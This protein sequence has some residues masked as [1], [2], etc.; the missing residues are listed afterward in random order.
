G[1]QPAGL[2]QRQDRVL[3]GRRRT[4]AGDRP[5]LL[6][7]LRHARLERRRE[8][9]VTQL[10]E[11]GVT[12]RQ[13]AVDQKRVVGPGLGGG[14]GVHGRGLGIL[15]G[16]GRGCDGGQGDGQ[17]RGERVF[18]RSILGNLNGSKGSPWRVEARA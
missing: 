13:G 1:Q 16:G 5:D 10:V 14:V 11:L 12:Q 7:F 6:Q 17:G 18:H 8:M 4:L 9:L 2:L 15:G 3:E